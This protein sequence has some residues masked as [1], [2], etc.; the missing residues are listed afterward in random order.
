MSTFVKQD[1]GKTVL[2]AVIESLNRATSFNRDVQVQ[3]APAAILWPDNDG[4]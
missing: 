2:D 3:V 4:H 1:T